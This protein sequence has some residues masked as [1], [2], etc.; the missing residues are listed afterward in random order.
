MADVDTCCIIYQLKKCALV[1]VTVLLQVPKRDNLQSCTSYCYGRR[2]SF[3]WYPEVK[4]TFVEIRVE[5][6]FSYFFMG[7]WIV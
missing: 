5:F 6:N 4:T 3:K 2:L 7:K 1:S